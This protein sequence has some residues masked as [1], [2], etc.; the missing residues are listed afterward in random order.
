M[1]TKGE[2]G[3]SGEERRMDGGEAVDRAVE[4]T[5]GLRSSGEERF[6][7]REVEQRGALGEKEGGGEMVD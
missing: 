7:V 6:E 4:K 3:E 1:R 5:G 2:G